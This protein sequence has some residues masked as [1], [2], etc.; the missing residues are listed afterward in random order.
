MNKKFSAVTIMLFAL[1]GLLFAG[2]VDA[3]PEHNVSGW[4]WSENIGWVSFTSSDLI[5]CPSGSCNASVNLI[6]GEISGWAKALSAPEAGWDGWIH[7][8]GS[9]YGVYLDFN[10]KE[11]KG[12][13]YGGDVVGWVSFNHLNCD[14]NGDGVS[15]QGVYS[16]C[17][18]GYP[19][20]DY[21][22]ETNFSFPPQIVDLSVSEMNYCTNPNQFFEWNFQDPDVLDTQSAYQLQIDRE[23][24]FL[25]FAAGEFDSGKVISDTEQKSVSVVREPSQDTLTY[26]ETYYWRI[27]VWDNSDTISEWFYGNSSFSTPPHIY[28]TPKFIWI[29][30]NPSA[31]EVVQFC[32]TT[33]G[34]ECS[35]FA[36][37]QV[38]QCYSPPSNPISCSGQT[39]NWSF[40]VGTDFEEGSITTSEN[41][42]V[43][44]S[45]FDDLDIIL[46][47]TDDVG[48]CSIT[49]QVNVTLPLPQWQ[50]T[51][52]Q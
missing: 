37:D 22:V 49:T 10:T 21:K 8:R 34:E 16:N 47:L 32:A 13:A 41:P 27:R 45:D 43:M 26:N 9:I 20:S 35:V 46:E 12:F 36:S 19:V 50:E 30:T 5:S 44:F 2:G 38:S 48:T 17:A 7:L 1:F 33:E 51:I 6:T 40:P 29:P 4:A 24:T 3:G 31:G 11:F 14:S 18:L 15:D 52:P 25:S 23:G 39:F 42:R 28:P